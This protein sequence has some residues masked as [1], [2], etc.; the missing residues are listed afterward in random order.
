MNSRLILILLIMSVCGHALGQ[1][2]KTNRDSLKSVGI[3]QDSVNYKTVEQYSKRNP[4]DSSKYQ[5][6]QKFSERSKFFRFL[7]HIIF[8]QVGR[9]SVPKPKK[10]VITKNVR[11]EGKIIRK[12]YITSLE[13]FGYSLADTSVHPVTVLEKAGN[14]MHLTTKEIII[15]NLL[16]F[17]EYEPYDSMLVEESGRLIR[18]QSYI[19]DVNI[20]TGLNSRKDSVDIYIRSM[21][22]W[23][24]IPALSITNSTFTMGLND[25]NFAGF[26]NG[27]QENSQMD[28]PTGDN[29]T[30]LSYLIPNIRNS[31]VSLNL[32]YSISINTNLVNNTLFQKYFFSPISSNNQYL[33]SANKNM[34]KSIDLERSFYSPLTKW[35]G[36]IF[37]GQMLTTQSY[38]KNDSINYLSSLTNIEDLWVG[39]SWQ[40]SKDNPVDGRITSLVLS[41][42]MLITRNPAR[43][44]DDRAANLFNNENFYFFGIGI[45][46]RKYYQDKYIF[47]YGKVEDIP[48]GRNIGITIGHDSKLRDRLYIGLMG[49]WGDYFRF[50]YLSTHLEYGTYETYKTPTGFQQGVFTARINY[51]TRLLDVGTWKLRQFVRPSLI[52]GIN[53]LPADVVTFSEGLKGFD[54]LGYSGT[55]MAVLTL[56]TQSYAPWNLVGFHFGPYFFT[57]LGILGNESS[58]FKTSRL[59]SLIGIGVLIRNDYLMFSTFQISFS[60]YPYIPGRGYDILRTNSYKT[61]DYGFRD[62]D[63]SKPGVVDYR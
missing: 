16:L 54:L 3:S 21:D 38:M 30:R 46:S 49:A 11:L 33:F 45:S 7:H 24:I 2:Q 12:I 13:P 47:N 44:A 27:F 31:Y 9:G 15:K 55:R 19:R 1:E 42:R 60:F 8:R 61:S 26:G 63:I 50:G 39:R 43:S 18:S 4:Q 36:G 53:R 29:I 10:T 35:A 5:A 25:I 17:K 41:G 37:L 58:G 51:F 14:S 40:L 32:Q 57:S 59:Y 62:F 28:R 56:Q 20:K 6:I 23:S 52:L 34:I 22:V 48:V